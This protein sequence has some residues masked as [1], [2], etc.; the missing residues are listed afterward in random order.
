[1]QY[2]NNRRWSKLRSNSGQGI[3]L[4]AATLVMLTAV[5]V[6]VV[7]LVFN[8][9]MVFLYQDRVNRIAEAGA[10]SINREMYWLGMNNPNYPANVGSVRKRTTNLIKEM[11]EAAGLASDD[12]NVHIEFDETNVSVGTQQDQSTATVTRV[13]LQVRGLR[14]LGGFCFPSLVT[15]KGT[16]TS[17]Q[18]AGQVYA[19]AVLNFYDPNYAGPAPVNRSIRL[20]IYEATTVRGGSITNVIKAGTLPGGNINVAYMPMANPGLKDAKFNGRLSMDSDTSPNGARDTATH[21]SVSLITSIS[22]RNLQW[23]VLFLR[24]Q[25]K[26]SLYDLIFPGVHR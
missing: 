2:I 12:R 22:Q 18:T 11:L 5:G 25:P 14:T 13:T 21:I 7:M 26:S 24:A 23:L 8:V 20:P 16:G 10:T 4:G 6:L 9:G 15:L 19:C 17:A 3:L 1:M